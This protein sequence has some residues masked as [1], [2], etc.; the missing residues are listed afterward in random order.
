[1]PY[2]LEPV[3]GMGETNFIMSKGSGGAGGFSFVQYHLDGT[4]KELMY[5]HGNGNVGIGTPNVRE[6]RSVN[7]MIRAWEIR[8]ETDNWP[9]YVFKK[10]YQLMT[11][12]SVKDLLIS[13]DICLISS[14]CSGGTRWLVVGEINRSLV[15]KVEE[16]T[17]Y[18]IAS[19]QRK[20]DRD[21][22]K[23]AQG[24]KLKAQSKRLELIEKRLTAKSK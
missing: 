21:I 1:M 14:R 4:K 17:L 18:Q 7:G 9:D 16:L 8:V 12:D 13:T 15:K 3:R 6:K 19:E 10:G 5:M 11:L 22:K 24:F 20:T 2:W 23:K